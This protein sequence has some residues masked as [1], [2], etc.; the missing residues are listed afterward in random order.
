MQMSTTPQQVLEQWYSRRHKHVLSFTS[1]EPSIEA[2]RAYST[3]KE[4]AL[5]IHP[6]AKA[7]HVEL[8][9]REL[10]AFDESSNCMEEYLC[11][12]AMRAFVRSHAAVVV[13][14]VTALTGL[15]VTIVAGRQRPP[16]TQPKRYP[17]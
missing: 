7:R 5:L 13:D 11:S 17:K 2:L 15:S 6:V 3:T 16:A 1:V 14:M 8:M 9:L 10:N 4:G 12:P